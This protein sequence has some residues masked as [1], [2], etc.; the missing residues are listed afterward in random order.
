M[1]AN[2]SL[3]FMYM[4][5]KF[6][7]LIIAAFFIFLWISS[8]DEKITTGEYYGFKIGSAKNETY[9]FLLESSGSMKL[10]SR[11]VLFNDE[12]KRIKNPLIIN[13]S[14][15]NEEYQLFENKDEWDFFIESPFFFDSIRLTFCDERLCK[16]W[17][18]REY[19]E[20]P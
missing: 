15:T 16:I 7:I 8:I 11:V 6:F 3:K 17:R 4:L 9:K 12:L 5:F 2:S 13:S 20:L 18:K 14:F 1:D 19:L 10:E